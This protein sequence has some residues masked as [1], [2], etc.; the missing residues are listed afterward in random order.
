MIYGIW[1]FLQIYFYI[2]TGTANSRFP[3]LF[4]TLY[5]YGSLI[6]LYKSTFFSKPKRSIILNSNWNDISVW[7]PPF[8]ADLC[9]RPGH[10]SCIIENESNHTRTQI[11]SSK[12][13]LDR[14][15]PSGQICWLHRLGWLNH[16]ETAYPLFIGQLYL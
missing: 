15:T 9:Y 13:L 4:F 3:V 6:L 14:C 11:K 12:F 8:E 7:S 5:I 10:Q 2:S 1:Y 16:D